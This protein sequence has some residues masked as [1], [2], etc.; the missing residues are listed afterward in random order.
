MNG[1]KDAFGR[2]AKAMPISM[3]STSYVHYIEAVCRY[4]S[5][6]MD[7]VYCT[8]LSFDGYHMGEEEKQAVMDYFQ[9]FLDL[10]PIAWD[11]AGSLDEPSARAVRVLKRLF[12]LHPSFHACLA[13]GRARFCLSE[14][15]AR[16]R[17]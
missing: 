5:L 12:F 3:V 4:L 14:E 15:R 16:S 17:R 7:S 2:I 8:R 10:P 6:S 11:D 1:V 9:R 13:M